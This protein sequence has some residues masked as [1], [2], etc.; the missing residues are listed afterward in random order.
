MTNIKWPSLKF[1]PINLWNCWQYNPKR[2]I[3]MNQLFSYNAPNFTNPD[4]EKYMNSLTYTPWADDEHIDLPDGYLKRCPYIS[5]AAYSE[6]IVASRY[7]RWLDEEGRRET[8]EEAVTRYMNFWDELGLL[9]KSNPLFYSIKESILR[10]EIMPSMRLLMTAGKAVK[11]DNAAAYNCAYR[12]VNGLIAFDEILYLLSVGTGVGFNCQQKFIDKLPEVGD[13]LTSRY[14]PTNENYP[15]INPEEISRF[16][17]EENTLHV[18]DSKYGWASA[19]RILITELY[20]GN[21]NIQWDTSTVRP[22]GARLKTFGGRASGP[23]P[24]VKLFEYVVNI[25]KTLINENRKRLKAIEVHGI[26][27]MIAHVIVVGGVR[28]SALISLSDLDD[29]DM[30]NAKRGEDWQSLHVE[31]YKANNSVYYD[32]LPD[33]MAFDSEWAAL[34]ESRSGERGFFNAIAAR[35]AINEMNERE[36]NRALLANEPT[37]QRRDPDAHYG[38]N[39]CSETF[40]ENGQFCNLTESVL[41]YDDTKQTIERK[42][43]YTTILGTLQST[44]TDFCYLSTEWKEATER[45]RLLGVSFTGIYDNEMMR[46]PSPTLDNF[47]NNLRAKVVATNKEWA[48]YLSIPQSQATTCI[49]PSGTVS[50]LVECS[51]GIHPRHAPFYRRTV[52]GD[53]KDPICTFIGDQ[54]LLKEP[55]KYDPL[56]SV[57]IY[58]PFKTI[59][60]KPLYRNEVDCIQQLELWYTYQNH[61]CEHKPSCTIYVEDDEWDKVAD[62]VFTRFNNLSG[63]SFLPKDNH[64]YPQAP[65]QDIDEETYNTLI[66]KCPTIIDWTK[67]RNYESE[68]GSIKTIVSCGGG[69]CD[70]I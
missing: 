14:L 42:V 41:R 30:R 6:Y 62:W 67:L 50:A 64:V 53:I 15:G 1:G 2:G 9:T 60:D 4:Y 17:V 32:H 66:E 22:K 23:G 69:N 12:V 57:V 10:T 48:G 29:E 58:F 33:R 51:S 7:S 25:F 20:K 35:K 65:F 3:S 47:L 59:T 40:L 5:N 19:V 31:Y 56:N 68:D 16:N 70:I 26:V 18:H 61:W 24:L 49:K 43:V 28:R 46:T 55:L 13:D 11:R 8:W 54:G 21:L 63:L 34:V 52:Q 45:G 36:Y 44:L 39:P 27:C 37:K 38:C